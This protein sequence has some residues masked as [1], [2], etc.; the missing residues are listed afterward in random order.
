MPKPRSLGLIRPYYS[1]VAGNK[2][3]S[4]SRWIVISLAEKIL[5]CKLAILA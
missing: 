2:G 5:A 1:G 3:S 4:N